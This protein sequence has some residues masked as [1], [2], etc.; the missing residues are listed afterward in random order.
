MSPARWRHS[1]SS[2]KSERV[3][4]LEA[5]KDTVARFIAA[6]PNDRI[7]LVAFAGRPYLVSPLTLDHDWLLKRLAAVE[8]GQVEDG[9]AIGSAI[10]SSANHLSDT[11]SEITPDDPA[12]RRHEQRRKGSS[13]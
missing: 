11:G 4:R 8:I 1:T 13:R 10:A 9:T 6:R 12:D 2:S 7:G 3:N 5:V